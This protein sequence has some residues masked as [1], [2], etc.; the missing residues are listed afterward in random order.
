MK[1]GEGLGQTTFV[2][3][4]AGNYLFLARVVEKGAFATEEKFQFEKQCK[5]ESWNDMKNIF[6][7]M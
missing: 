5:A 6:F 4:L 2:V 1:P 3:W 7:M